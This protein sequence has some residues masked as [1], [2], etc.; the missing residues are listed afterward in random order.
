MKKKVVW[1]S[2]TGVLVL[3]GLSVGFKHLGGKAELQNKSMEQIY[4]ESGVPVKVKEVVAGQFTKQ[5]KYSAILKARSEAVCYSRVSD[6]V[7]EV[8]FKVGD[9]VRKDQTVITFP[10]NNQKVQYYQLKASYDLAEQTYH[11]LSK[12]YEQGVISKQELDNARTSYEVAKANLRITDDSLRVK[13]PLSGYITQLNVKPTDNV[14][15]EQPLFTVSNLDQIEAQLWASSQEIDQIKPGQKVT[16][17]WDGTQFEGFVSQVGQIMDGSKKAFEVRALFKNKNN[18]LTS[19]I[20]ADLAIETY[21]NDQA[22]TVHRKDVVSENGKQYVYV[23]DNG[24]AVK[25][26]IQTGVAEGTV[27]EV[28]SGLKLGDLLITEGNKMVADHTKVKI[29]RS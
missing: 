16:L 11:R 3:T 2:I 25:R 22:I 12:L 4:Q 17:N 9:Y 24:V 10:K 26:E 29:V 14:S 21:R 13:A 23:V 27:I 18:I 28:K 7:Q 19:G 15:S 6:V 1:L 5:L 8:L 20:T